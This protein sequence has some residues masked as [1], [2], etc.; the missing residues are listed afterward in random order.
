M[1]LLPF[2]ALLHINF[3]LLQIF[4]VAL[5]AQ[6]NASDMPWRNVQ[7][8]SR[9]LSESLLQGGDPFP[10]GKQGRVRPRGEVQ[11]AQDVADM[12]MHSRLAHHQAIRYLPIT[13]PLG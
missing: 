3:Q 12:R 6:L 13:Q 1:D 7:I 8:E 2:C 4:G 11:F 9:T 5:A 10:H